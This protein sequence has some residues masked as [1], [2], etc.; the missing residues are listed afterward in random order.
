MKI[1]IKRKLHEGKGADIIA[2]GLKINLLSDLSKKVFDRLGGFEE[3]IEGDSGKINQAIELIIALGSGDRQSM[4]NDSNIFREFAR[5]SEE[6]V[7]I[8]KRKYEEFRDGNRQSYNNEIDTISQ[9]RGLDAGFGAEND[10]FVQQ[11]QKSQN[12][13][14]QKY[15]SDIKKL[16]EKV[17]LYNDIAEKLSQA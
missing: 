7:S 16:Q 17:D 4:E 1:R 5:M 13:K 12:Q 6:N 14:E 8:K 11:M 10:F 3:V 9:G 15:L 2:R